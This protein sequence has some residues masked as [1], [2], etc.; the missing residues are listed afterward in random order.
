MSFK[1]ATVCSW[2]CLV[3]I[4]A[5]LALVAPFSHA[6][7]ESPGIKVRWAFAA[8]TMQGEDWQLQ[9]LGADNV[10]KTGDLLKIMV[11]PRTP[12]FVYVLHCGPQSDCKLLYPSSVSAPEETGRPS[13]RQFVP[14]GEDWFE[15]DSKRGQETFHLLA[16]KER[17]RGLEQIYQR[18]EQAPRDGRL[19]MSEQLQ[20]EIKDLKRKHRELTSVAER[21][22][23]IGGAIRGVELTA[24]AKKPDIAPLANDLSASEFI[25]RTFTIDHQ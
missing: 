5:G 22:V 3:L 17:L 21:P 24:G 7:Q 15:L 11:E 9:R 6:A 16:S 10:L 4:A 8:L 14:P 18:Y 25:A 23:A 12:C 13:G 2:K 1:K 20:A 19:A